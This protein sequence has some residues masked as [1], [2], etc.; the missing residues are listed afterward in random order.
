M[1]IL[2]A[3]VV[4]VTLAACASPSQSEP[5]TPGD[6]AGT[7][8]WIEIVDDAR[9]AAN[10]HN[11]QSWRLRVEPDGSVTGGLDPSRLLP[12]TDPVGRQLVISL[13]TLSEA[14]R[15]AARA[16]GWTLEATWIAPTDWS[17]DADPGADLFRWTA[18]PLAGATPAAGDILDG[19]TTPTVKYAIAPETVPTDLA[20][21]IP[22]TYS[23]ADRGIRVLVEAGTPRTLTTMKLA[24]A[25]FAVEMR[26]EPTLMESY[27][28]TRIGNRERRETPWG[29]SLNAN[30]GRLAFTF[31]D[32]I[33]TLF[34]QTPEQ[35]GESGIDLFNGAVQDE[36]GLVVLTTSD[37]DPATWFAAGLPLQALWMELR[38]AGL[39]LLPL[40][41]GLQEY[42]EVAEFYGQFH[43]LWVPD[44]GTVQMI[45]YVGAPSA[46]V[47]PSPRL[48]AEAV[49]V[50]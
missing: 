14:A 44:G 24:R 2:F 12:E 33:T 26:H 23:N 7:P 45:L 25:A 15:R 40:S 16:R 49:V 46:R 28:L 31:V 19:L 50:Q 29:L 9:W 42:P 34:R 20:R 1:R 13:G 6:V 21:S 17:L 18:T 38:A 27:T 37:N 35:F 11:V 32:P 8:P 48:A 5:S 4:A 3:F 41:Q 10:A 39:E 36:G 43:D 30:F 22:A 47:Y